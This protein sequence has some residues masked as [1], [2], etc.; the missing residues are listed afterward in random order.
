LTLKLIGRLFLVSSFGTLILAGVHLVSGQSLLP[1]DILATL[2][3]NKVYLIIISI[4]IFTNTRH[5]LFR[6]RDQEV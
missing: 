6:I 2:V 4:L 5:I 1:M 3:A